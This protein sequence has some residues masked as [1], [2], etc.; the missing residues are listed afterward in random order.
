MIAVIATLKVQEA[1]TAEFES[2]MRALAEKV[3]ANEPGCK[4]YV[5]CAVKNAPGTYRMLER[6][7]DRA[8]LQHHSGTD[9][10]KATFAKIGGV[11]AAPPQIDVMEEVA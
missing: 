3:R 5:M 1:K 7:D 10:F 8:A 4:L 2:A 11:F 9:Y 6:Y